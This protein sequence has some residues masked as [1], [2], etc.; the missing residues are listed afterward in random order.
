[1]AENR[2]SVL[3]LRIHDHIK[4]ALWE[5]ADENCQEIQ[6]VAYQLLLDGLKMKIVRRSH[7]QDKKFFSHLQ[8]KSE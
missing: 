8:G 5:L 6:E 4:S 3:R 2:T 7:L 1:M